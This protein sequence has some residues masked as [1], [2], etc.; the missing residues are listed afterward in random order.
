MG[1]IQLL[2][3]IYHLLLFNGFFFRLLHYSTVHKFL[4]YRSGR[5][6]LLMILYKKHF[7]ANIFTSFFIF[8]FWSNLS[9]NQCNFRILLLLSYS[10]SLL[11]QGK[12]R[13]RTIAL[14]LLENNTLQNPGAHS[15]CSI[16]LICQSMFA[17]KLGLTMKWT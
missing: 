7:S 15:I 17:L 14:Q 3:N 2:V 5:S 9:D 11:N 4:K 1:R 16:C 13:L 8:P 10:L 6:A 12:N